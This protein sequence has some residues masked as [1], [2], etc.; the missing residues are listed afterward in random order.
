MTVLKRPKYQ[1]SN[2][3]VVMISVLHTEGLQFDPGLDQLFCAFLHDRHQLTPTV[4]GH[5]YRPQL[6]DSYTM[7]ILFIF[8]TKAFK[9]SLTAAAHPHTI[10]PS[11]TSGITTSE[12]LQIS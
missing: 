9:N 3:L 1:R 5:L 10:Y 2:G 4:V 11:C 6:G 7:A 8:H 12:H